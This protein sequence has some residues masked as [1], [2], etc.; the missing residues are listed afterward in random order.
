MF[1]NTVVICNKVDKKLESVLA[2]YIIQVPALKDWQVYD[3]VKQICRELDQLEIEWLYKVANGNIYKIESEL[4][5]LLLFHPKAR[6]QVLAHLR[7]DENSDL[8]NLSV[9]ELCDAI[10]YNKKKVI[11]SPL[12]A[13]F[14]DGSHISNFN[15]ELFAIDSLRYYLLSRFL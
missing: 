12:T 5:K 4:D 10:I 2:D 6:K 3:Y 13:F 9:F 11:T 7:F 1:E 8:Y 15:C 14:V